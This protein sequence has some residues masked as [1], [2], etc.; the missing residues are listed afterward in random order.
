M[1]IWSY[2]LI[3]YVFFIAVF[4]F[5]KGTKRFVTLAVIAL[6]IMMTWK[7]ILVM[8]LLG[9]IGILYLAKKV[10]VYRNYDFRG[11]ENSNNGNN[12]NYG[13]YEGFGGF[14]N[15]SNTGRM[16]EYY[17]ELEV[18]ENATDEELKKSHKRLV[19]TYHPDVHHDKSE[20]ERKKYED[21][22]KKINE[23][24]EN[25]KKSRGL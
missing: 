22:F 2:A 18:E 1:N 6:I 20:Q 8:I 10:K 16:K 4:G 23:A 13:S 12:R 14:E 17:R 9:I 11:F 19:R 21:K 15:F 24:Y 3:A 7:I 25:I 5:K